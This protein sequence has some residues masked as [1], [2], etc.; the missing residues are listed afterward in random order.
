MPTVLVVDDSVS[1]RKVMERALT[2]RDISVIAAATG[3]EAIERIESE[4][5]DAVVCD[6]V[7][8]DRDGY[9]VCQFVKTHP[10]LGATPVLL[11]S[12]VVNSTVLARAAEVQS[13]DVMF[14]PFAADELVKKIDDLLV[15]VGSGRRAGGETRRPAVFEGTG[16]RAG[17]TLDGTGAR[18][19][20]T[21]VPASTSPRVS[22]TP[23]L[24]GPLGSLRAPLEAFAA[25]PGVRFAALVDREGFLIEIA[26][27]TS[28]PVDVA[29]ALASCLAESSDGLGRELGQGELRGMILEFADGVL[30]LHG[31][32][33]AALLVI[34]VRDPGVLGKVRYVVK[35]TLPELAEAL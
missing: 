32:G 34:L 10:R 14:K 29:G 33:A 21:P 28:L 25:T 16:S 26:G 19:I 6:V 3:T 35:K 30:L 2:A 8:P 13:N 20:A 7:L 22:T 4:A 15:R 12:G 23:A 9:Q 5:P 31:V 27:E 11:V 1:V 24:A 18:A 17:A